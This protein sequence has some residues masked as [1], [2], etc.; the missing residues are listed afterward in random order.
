MLMYLAANTFTE[1]AYVVHKAA[2]LS[3][4]P[5]NIHAL[6]IMRTL[7]Y[8]KKTQDNGIWMCLY[9]IFKLYCY[10]NLDFGGLPGSEG[11]ANPFS[12]KSISGVSYQVWKCT[13]PKYFQT[14]N[15]NILSY[16]GGRICYWSQSMQ[17]I[18]P[19]RAVIKDITSSC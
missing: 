5:K 11:P 12:V 16:N 4:N 18:I 9:E 2:R 13:N 8:L 19:L 17:E 15:S 1:I 7:C 3:Q 10:L 14:P 6:V